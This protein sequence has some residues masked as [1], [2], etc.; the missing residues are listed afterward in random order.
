MY[1]TYSVKLDKTGS[2]KRVKLGSKSRQGSHGDRGMRLS[3]A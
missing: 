1:F 3:Q 2:G